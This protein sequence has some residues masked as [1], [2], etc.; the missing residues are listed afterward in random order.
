M[1]CFSCTQCIVDEPPPV[2][3]PSE[4][5]AVSLH[6]TTAVSSIPISSS[7]SRDSNSTSGVSLGLVHHGFCD[8]YR[9]LA[10][11]GLPQHIVNLMAQHPG[12]SVLAT[13]HSLGGAAAT[14]AAADLSIRY[15]VYVVWHACVCHVC[16]SMCVSCAL[17]ICVCTTT[18]RS[19]D[20]WSVMRYTYICPDSKCRQ[21]SYCCTHLV[22][23]GLAMLSLLRLWP[24]TLARHTG[25]TAAILVARLQNTLS[26]LVLRVLMCA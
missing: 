19:T 13:G 17:R 21:R 2:P 26:S 25:T 18:D 8:Y 1:Y 14:I 20:L 3:E 24:T 9:S 10:D 15:V 4:A 6:A 12:Y 23:L 5:A 22:L 16:S 7:S 11:L